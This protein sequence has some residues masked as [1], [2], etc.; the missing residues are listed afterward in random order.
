MGRGGLLGMFTQVGGIW[1]SYGT[2]L[3]GQRRSATDVLR[4]GIGGYDHDG[5][6]ARRQSGRHRALVALWRTGTAPWTTSAPLAL[7]AAT[8]VRASAVGDDAAIAVVTVSGSAASAYSIDPGG[9]WNRIASPPA[10]TTA[11][12]LPSGPATTDGSA[13]DA[14][15]VQGGV[16]GVYAL[17]PSGGTWVRVQSS[18]VAIAY[19]SSS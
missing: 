3:N 17:T 13:I 8:S 7:T 4:L 1:S 16:L 19:G 6:R 9:P 12:A 14:F 11:I 5:A 18:Q 10:H 15:T 2:A